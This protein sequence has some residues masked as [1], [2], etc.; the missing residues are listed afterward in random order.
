MI[1]I[2][3]VKLSNGPAKLC[4]FGPKIKRIL[5]IFKKILIFLIKISM[6]N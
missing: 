4:A 3:Q 5:K 1:P 6:E 2:A